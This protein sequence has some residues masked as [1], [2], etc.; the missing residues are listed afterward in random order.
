MKCQKC[1]LDHD[2]SFGSGKYCS[3]KCANSRG[4]RNDIFKK[5]VSEKLKGTL[6]WNSGKTLTEEHKEKISNSGKGKIRSRVSDEEVFVE[7]SNV[8][9]HVAKK[10]IIRDLL[11][12]YKCSCCNLG[13][14]WNDKPIVLQLDHINGVNDDHR[15]ENL[16]F[17]CPNCHTQQDTY[18]AKN[19][20]NEKRKPKKY[21]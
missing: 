11:I 18:A 8:S 19:R 10:R 5:K 6:P 21:I 13:S 12:E 4:P 9:R 1:N 17:L 15:L 16:R 2:G 3:R 7:N 14:I 20:F